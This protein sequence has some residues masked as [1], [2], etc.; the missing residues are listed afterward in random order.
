MLT[1]GDVVS[2]VLGVPTGNEVG[3]PKRAIIVTAQEIL[4]RSP[5]VVH[6]VPLT[7]TRRNVQSELTI[8]PGSSGLSRPSAAQCQHVRSVS[9]SRISGSPGNVG[10]VDLVRIRGMLALI[11]DLP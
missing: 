3:F 8:H 2:I 10:P 9:A 11:F 1:S 5:T 4:D 7:S 6:I